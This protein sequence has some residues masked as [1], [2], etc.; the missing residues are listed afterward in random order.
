MNKEFIMENQK[1]NIGY[2]YQVLG[3]VVDVKFTNG[4]LPSINDALIINLTPNEN[5]EN[6]KKLTL[7]V[8]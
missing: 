3:P 4:T 8:A 2:V 5:N 6:Q 7:E 1:E